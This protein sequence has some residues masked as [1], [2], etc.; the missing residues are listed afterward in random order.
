[1]KE[2]SEIVDELMW[3][4]KKFPLAALT[5]AVQRREEIT[6]YLLDSLDYMAA[7]AKNSRENEHPEERIYDLHTYA[8]YLLAQ[9]KEKRAFPKLARLINFDEATLDFI[10]S[11]TLTDRYAAILRDT[12][13]G[14]IEP[15]KEVIEN[16][17]AFSFAR[18][19]ALNAFRLI[20]EAG[21]ISRGEL[22][23]YLRLLIQETL[24]ANEKSG[25]E[26][27]KELAENIEF[28]SSITDC[29]MDSH[30]I[31]MLDDI[32][33]LFAMDFIDTFQTGAYDSF[34]NTVFDYT[35]DT[36]GHEEP[37]EDVIAE[38]Q[39]WV[40][41][42]NPQAQ[43]KSQ[44]KAELL[45]RALQE[46]HTITKAQKKVGRNDP[47]PCGSGKKY[48]KC[49]LDKDQHKEQDPLQVI[50]EGG[51]PYNLLTDFPD[52][53]TKSV[54]NK[55]AFADYFKAKAIEIDIPVYKA[56]HHRMISIFVERDSR[57][58]DFGKIHF[59]LE[60]FVLF[61]NLCRSEYITSFEEF[62]KMYMVHYSALVWV[63]AL[64]D[65]LVSYRRE[66]PP[67]ISKMLP[68]VQ[69]VLQ[70]MDT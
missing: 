33:K 62:D 40:S 19:A 35:T 31:E 10:I 58:E 27:K 34:L 54:E 3:Y 15:L 5:E 4:T 29:V 37:V 21:F 66:L 11:D 22:I 50:G 20:S 44:Q 70:D 18:G 26:L 61:Q 25:E 48:K 56:L 24:K 49:C 64:Y 16:R 43:Q 28:F 14:N 45:A 68:E 67:E 12:Y 65:L 23:A 6:P 53:K 63:N 55:P 47:C 1:M 8:M 36:G 17:D 42:D 9:F 41:Y 38:M 57:G 59:L 13:D 32:K 69:R 51:R 2:I 46:M 39:N 30:L 52:L 7:N 60:A